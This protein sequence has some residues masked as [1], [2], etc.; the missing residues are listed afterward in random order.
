M[1]A[2]HAPRRRHEDGGSTRAL[3][4]LGGGRPRRVLSD[5]VPPHGRR[6]RASALIRLEEDIELIVLEA[7]KSLL[8]TEGQWAERNSAQTLPADLT[9]ALVAP[10]MGALADGLAA[11]QIRED[12]VAVGEG[13]LNIM[14]AACREPGGDEAVRYDATSSVRM[15]QIKQYIDERIGEPTLRPETVA[16]AHFMSTRALQ[17]M[18]QAEG[19]TV[20][21]WI[22]DRRLAGARRDLRDPR[23]LDVPIAAI[24]AAWG[25]PNPGHFSRLFRATLGMT[26]REYRRAITP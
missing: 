15:M 14:R 20:T 12:D 23:L 11:G 1:R 2:R 16:A 10:F 4:L 5:D 24:G 8:G 26:P 13:A 6:R 19:L 7:P 25:F 17:K 22:R 18:F 9:R 3:R 21:D